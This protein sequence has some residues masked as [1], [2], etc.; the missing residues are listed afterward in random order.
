M[1]AK[2]FTQHPETDYN[3]TFAPVVRKKSIYAVLAIA[4]AEDLEAENV[5]VDIAFLYGEVEEEIY[6]DQPARIYGR[7]ETDKEGF[8]A[9]S[10]YETKQAARQL[11][12]KLNEHL[13]N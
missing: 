2:D 10:F 11:H 3:K 5:D 1:V 7:K 12:S 9:E 6:L 4:G 13:E 8:A